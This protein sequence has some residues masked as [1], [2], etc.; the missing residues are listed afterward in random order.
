MLIRNRVLLVTVSTISLIQI[1]DIHLPQFKTERAVDCKDDGISEDLLSEL[2]PPKIQTVVRSITK[3]QEKLNYPPLLFCGDLSSYGS[4]SEYKDCVKY[5]VDVLNL[6]KRK[7][8]TIHV[9]PGNHDIDRKLCTNKN[10][11]NLDS[12]FIPLKEAWTSAGIDVLAV[13]EVRT[14]T[15]NEAAGE[16]HIYSLNSCIG[17]G[18]WRAMPTKIQKQFGTVVEEY[19]SSVSEKEAFE[20]AGEQLDTPMIR[21]TDLES[22]NLSLDALPKNTLPII[23]AHHNILPQ[24]LQRVDLYTELINSGP[25]RTTLT[26]HSRPIVYCHGHIHTDPI[27]IISD[28]TRPLSR[29]ITISAPI[30][31]AGFNVLHIHFSRTQDPIGIE[32]E[33]YRLQE[34]GN[35]AKV[36]SHRIPLGDQHTTSFS[37]SDLAI[38][39]ELLKENQVFRFEELRNK[40]NQQR[41]PKANRKTMEQILCEA[42]WKGLISIKDR[43]YENKCW[44]IRRTFQ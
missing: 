30:I 12:K 27:E 4:T 22:L 44:V 21:S 7:P 31:I 39:S 23:L 33:F 26:Q 8:Q 34:S 11:L 43:N 19:A 38:L 10:E 2:A 20:L 29:V 17:C 1:G 16:L 25:F 35:V 3:L 28:A 42:E 14:S 13:D 6:S 37:D 36:N 24:S 32:I 5:L 40:I 9:V 41:T 15:I 18:E